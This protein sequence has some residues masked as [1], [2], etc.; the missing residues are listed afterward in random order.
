MYSATLDT[1]H[2]LLINGSSNSNN[3]IHSEQKSCRP[4]LSTPPVPVLTPYTLT[5]LFFVQKTYTANSVLYDSKH[6]ARVACGVA[7]AGRNITLASKCND[8]GLRSEDKIY[9]SIHHVYGHAGNAGNECADIAAS[10]GTNGFV[11]ECKVPSFWPT[12]Q[13]FLQRFFQRSPLSDP[14]SRL[15]LV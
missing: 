4:P 9:I 12:R 2:D 11:P 15:M 14:Q 3:S 8:L 13:F 5:S 10:F 7:H 6:A 1:P